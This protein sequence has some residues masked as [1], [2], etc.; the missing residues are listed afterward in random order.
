MAKE[1][2]V[3][4]WFKIGI[5][6]SSRHINGGKNVC[7]VLS[8]SALLNECEVDITTDA[9]WT[10]DDWDLQHVLWAFERKEYYLI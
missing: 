2:I 3:P 5:K 8:F 10:E 9:N 7:E 6:F 4:E 1:V